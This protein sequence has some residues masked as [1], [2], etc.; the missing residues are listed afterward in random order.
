MN[1]NFVLKKE[2][3]NLM[4][5]LDEPITIRELQLIAKVDLYDSG[6]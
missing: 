3:L 4:T 1:D 6:F 2:W 5:K